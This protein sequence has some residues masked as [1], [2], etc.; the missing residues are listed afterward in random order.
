MQVVSRK[1]GGAFVSLRNL[2]SLSNRIPEE[3]EELLAEESD[4]RV[5][6]KEGIPAKEELHGTCYSVSPSKKV[7]QAFLPRRRRSWLSFRKQVVGG[8]FTGYTPEFDAIDH[9]LLEKFLEV[10]E[11][12]ASMNSTDNTPEQNGSNLKSCAK[13]MTD[14]LKTAYQH[15]VL[16]NLALISERLLTRVNLLYSRISNN[17][18]QFC[19][20]LLINGDGFDAQFGY[21]YPY[22]P[23][24]IEQTAQNRC[25]RYLMSFCRHCRRSSSI[26]REGKHHGHRSQSIRLV[27][28]YRWCRHYRLYRQ[29]SFQT[30]PERGIARFHV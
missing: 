5:T 12:W 8:M 27:S 21:L 11:Q 20:S 26:L 18:Q 28:A 24:F 10:A 23:S 15:D 6:I 3:V 2:P 25:L 14:F 22:Q 1:P 4:F 13:K 7:Y 30:R 16:M 19:K 9:T 29:P 17:C